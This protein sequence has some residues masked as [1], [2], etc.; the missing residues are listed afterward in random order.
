V[1]GERIQGKEVRG[2]IWCKYSVCMYV[3]GKMSPVETIPGMGRQGMKGNGGGGEFH[4][5]KL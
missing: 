5:N 1:R 4:H 3:N 2:R